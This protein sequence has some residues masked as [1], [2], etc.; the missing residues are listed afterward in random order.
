MQYVSKCSWER[1][2]LNFAGN[3]SINIFIFVLTFTIRSTKF[4]VFVIVKAIFLSRF[5]S[6]SELHWKLQYH[7]ILLKK[8]RKKEE[9]ELPF[10][11][12]Q[13]VAS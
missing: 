12:M 5:L 10:K 11:H 8:L 13:F 2:A 3:S 4:T 9:S 1:T 7:L 6:I